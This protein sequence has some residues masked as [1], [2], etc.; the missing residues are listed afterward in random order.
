MVKLRLLHRPASGLSAPDFVPVLSRGRHRSPRR[1][2]CFMEMASYLAGE[3]WSDHP[4]CTDA[5]LAELA[6]SV[7]DATSDAGRQRLAP[8]IP[9]VVGLR[10]ADPA[11]RP[12]LARLAATAALGVSAASTQRVVAVGL[13]RCDALLAEVEGRSTDCLSPGAQATLAAVPDA[14]EWA[15]RFIA[16]S[17]PPTRRS[18]WRTFGDGASVAIVRTSVAGIAHACIPDPDDRLV[19]LLAGAIELCRAAQVDRSTVSAALR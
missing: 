1:G 5:L 10:P 3:R 9:D 18:V 14:A 19:D 2:A 17:S 6:R 16:R 12:A 4:A 15:R 11:V 13:L 7:N 8:L